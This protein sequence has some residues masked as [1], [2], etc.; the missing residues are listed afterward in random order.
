MNYTYIKR[1]ELKTSKI[2]TFQPTCS[3]SGLLVARAYLDSSR[4]LA[5]PNPKHQKIAAQTGDL[6][7]GPGF[8][9]GWLCQPGNLLNFFGPQCLYL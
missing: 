5:G 3:S 8:A 2:I 4:R 1:D 9:T 6:G 7:S